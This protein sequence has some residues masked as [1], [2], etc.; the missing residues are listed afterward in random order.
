MYLLLAA[1]PMSCY[2]HNASKSISYLHFFPC[3]LDHIMNKL[4]IDA[5]PSFLNVLVSLTDVFNAVCSAENF[6]IHHFHN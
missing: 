3:L 4:T 5:I 1:A 6:A 2:V